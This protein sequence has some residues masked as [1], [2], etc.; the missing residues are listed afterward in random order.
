MGIFVNKNQFEVQKTHDLSEKNL[1][2]EVIDNEVIKDDKNNV[3]AYYRK[4]QAEKELKNY[5]N[6]LESI[7]K[8]SALSSDAGISLL[9]SQIK[10]L[11]KKENE[12]Y[13]KM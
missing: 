8:A 6:A 12:K 1:E 7:S 4:A 13:K 3:K 5:E 11:L 2:T 10:E 9:K